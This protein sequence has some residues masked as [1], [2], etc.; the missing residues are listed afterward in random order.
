MRAITLLIL[1]LFISG[2]AFSQNNIASI[3]K[4][5][6]ILVPE[7]EMAAAGGKVLYLPMEYGGKV[8]LYTQKDAFEIL[9]DAI[10]VRVDLVY[11]DYPAKK[12]FSALSKSRLE[13]LQK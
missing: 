7:Y 1:T 9:Q 5:R 11:T 6:E 3:V 13:A 2:I 4:Q 8:F 12:D 10:I